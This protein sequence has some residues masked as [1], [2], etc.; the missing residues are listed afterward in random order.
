MEQPIEGMGSQAAKVV[1]LIRCR[2]IGSLTDQLVAVDA[3]DWLY[4][5]GDHPAAAAITNHLQQSGWDP[6]SAVRA[7]QIWEIVRDLR[8][9]ENGKRRPYF[10]DNSL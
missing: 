6:E 10:D 1:G 9:R 5:Q 7:G 4:R 2:G 3:F 8:D